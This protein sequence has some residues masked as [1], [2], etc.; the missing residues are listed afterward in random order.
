MP[1][2][3]DFAKVP[4]GCQDLEADHIRKLNGQM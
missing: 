3:I 1:G 2:E 4:G